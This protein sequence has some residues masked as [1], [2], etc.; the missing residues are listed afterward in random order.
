MDGPL[1]WFVNRGTGFSLL[2][3]LTGA[4]LL[5]IL[6]TGGTPARRLPVFVTQSLHRNLSLLSVLMLLVHVASAVA[7]RYVDIRWWQALSPV[8][9][10]YRPLWLGLGTVA[11]DLILL[12]TLTSVLRVRIP[13]RLWRAVHLLSYAAWASAVVHGLGIGTDTGEAWARWL[14]WTCVGLVSLALLGR[15]V[16]TRRGRGAR[17]SASRRPAVLR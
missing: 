7:D 2:V 3:L 16:A 1:L 4:V 8:G 12:V 15:L 9:A 6:S 13:Q 11:L 17:G 5:G 14:T 10:T